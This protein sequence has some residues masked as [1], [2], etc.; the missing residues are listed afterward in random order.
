MDR[1]PRSVGYIVP[2]APA[3]AGTLITAVAEPWFDIIEILLKDPNAAFQIPPEQWEKI[4]AGAYKKANFDEVI[5][6]PRGGYFGR[7]VIAV[8]GGLACSH[9]RS[10]KKVRSRHS[11]NRQRRACAYG[12]SYKQMEQQRAFSRRHPILLPS[13]GSIL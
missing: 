1:P 3:D 5:L 4:V 7:D 12:R 10:G 11:R 9:N 6:T 2:D 13:F 8:K